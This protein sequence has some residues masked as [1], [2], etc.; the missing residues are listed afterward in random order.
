MDIRGLKH[1]YQAEA[2]FT[3][4]I[5]LKLSAL[6]SSLLSQDNEAGEIEALVSALGEELRSAVQSIEST[7]TDEDVADASNHRLREELKAILKRS[8]GMLTL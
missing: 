3:E 7:Q 2:I 8:T 4:Q 5:V 1:C 6:H